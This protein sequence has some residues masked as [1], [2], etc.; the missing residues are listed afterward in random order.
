M[1]RWI[2]ALLVVGAGWSAGP[3]ADAGIPKRAATT[4][5]ASG[6][7]VALGKRYFN[8]TEG[9]SLCPP[10]DA[11]TVRERAPSRSVTWNVTD[12]ATGAV[13]WVLGVVRGPTDL[14]AEKLQ[15]YAD[16]KIRQA[17][18]QDRMTLE[19]CRVITAAGRPAVDVRMV[20]VEEG[21]RWSRSVLILV[22]DKELLMLALVGPM[23][24]KEAMLATH[25]AVLNSLELVDPKVRAMQRETNL[26]AGRELLSGLTAERLRGAVEKEDFWGLILRDGEVEGFWVSR[27]RW[28]ES[29]GQA[30]VEGR[31]WMRVT[32][33]DGT[34]QRLDVV[35]FAAA[36]RSVEDWTAT[37][38]AT[39]AKGEA[40]GA[41]Q[42]SLIARLSKRGKSVELSQTLD[43][44]D[45]PPIRTS[46][47]ETM[48]RSYLPMVMQSLVPRVADLGAKRSYAFA[49]FAPGA[50]TSE[51][52]VYTFEVVGP[53]P[54][55]WGGQ[56]VQAGHITV[57]SA[58]DQEAQDVWLDP[59][60]RLLR[61]HL[62]AGAML[63]RSTREEVLRRCPAAQEVLKAIDAG[64]GGEETP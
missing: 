59:S 56:K 61:Q 55:E 33:P 38:H 22:K 30:G 10:A 60:G 16:E 62:S 6:K 19:S 31:A 64:A 34:V 9:Y 40:G 46:L 2:A 43:G 1:G 35:S 49:A 63:E 11:Q 51:L 45:G 24:D 23:A 57:R 44:K 25:E 17:A 21:Q 39:P 41:K 50:K 48:D 54:I 53:E 27:D 15:A 42:E 8:L 13:A 20:M 29:D 32:Q 7:A 3:A 37:A 26:A 14:T 36:D 5:A 12:K 28:T 4:R 52:D 18:G 58:E 47:S